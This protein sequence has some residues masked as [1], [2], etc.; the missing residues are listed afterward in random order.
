MLKTVFAA[1]VLAVA[2]AGSA[3]AA[4]SNLSGTVTT[5]VPTNFVDDSATNAGNVTGAS[6]STFMTVQNTSPNVGGT[7]T[8]GAG[9][10]PTGINATTVQLTFYVQTPNPSNIT[11][12]LNRI[13]FT[14]SGGA[15]ATLS[16]I[17]FSMSPAS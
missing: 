11:A 6:N 3:F 13:Q 9:L 7:W 16:A 8:V 17:G 14:D 12:A 5:S 4:T 15:T 10:S 2:S 1:F